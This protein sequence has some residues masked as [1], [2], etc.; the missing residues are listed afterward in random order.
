MK[1]KRQA[2]KMTRLK[3]SLIAV[4][5][6]MFRLP[7]LLTSEMVVCNGFKLL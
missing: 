5:I 2:I 6:N 7:D 3:T 1:T 4:V